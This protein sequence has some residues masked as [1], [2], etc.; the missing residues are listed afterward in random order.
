M[1]F[2]FPC[3]FFQLYWFSLFPCVFHTPSICIEHMARHALLCCFCNEIQRISR[4]KKQAV[5]QP[6]TFRGAS[7]HYVLDPMF[8]DKW[9]KDKNE[10]RINPPSLLP[11]NRYSNVRGIFVFK[12]L[13]TFFFC[14]GKQT[15]SSLLPL[16]SLFQKEHTTSV[17][18]CVHLFPFSFI[19]CLPLTFCFFLVDW[20]DCRHGKRR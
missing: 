6:A 1:L 3:D 8:H 17:G 7:N 15:L 4:P 18:K 11:S 13:Q 10:W 20:Y 14:Y 9:Q 5:R 19:S 12:R 16:S 2:G